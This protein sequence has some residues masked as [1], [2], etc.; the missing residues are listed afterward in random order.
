LEV[1]VYDTERDEDVWSTGGGLCTG[2]SLARIFRY[3]AST[4]QF[5]RTVTER[6]KAILSKA[7]QLPGLAGM[8]KKM[9]STS[10]EPLT[11]DDLMLEEPDRSNSV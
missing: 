4:A 2:L 11:F 9:L 1:I 10:G 5:W 6:V 7:R 3:Q 8:A